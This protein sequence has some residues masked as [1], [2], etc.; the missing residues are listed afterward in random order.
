M[1]VSRNWLEWVVA[2]GW[3][4]IGFVFLFLGVGLVQSVILAYGTLA[5]FIVAFG[6]MGGGIAL[7]LHAVWHVVLFEE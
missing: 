6:V 3:V 7:L 4:T 2:T 5:G 1:I